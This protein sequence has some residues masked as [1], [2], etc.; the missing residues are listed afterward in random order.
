MQLNKKNRLFENNR[1]IYIAVDN[2]KPNPAQPRK[3]FDQE[4][5]RE[6]SESIMKFGV[7]QPLSVRKKSD[8][9]ELIA[10][11]RRLRAAKLAGLGE[12]PCILLGVDREQSS[13]LAL[14]ENLQRQDLDF[15]EEAE[16][17]A[18]LILSFGLSQEEAA[19][20]IGKSQSAVANKLRILKHPQ[21]VLDKLRQYNL[22]ERHARAL[23]RLENTQDRLDAIEE[24]AKNS[25]NVAQTEELVEKILNSPGSKAAR[26]VHRSFTY[27]IKD[28]RIFENTI[29]HAVSIM[30]DSG[31]KADYGKEEDE[32]SI[33]LTIKIP[34]RAS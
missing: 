13:V 20:K 15:I 21:E 2:I 23:L 14:I 31:V 34:K 3:L 11:E 29:K 1:I 19:R 27:I 7:L 25:L 17:I 10:G 22:T 28:F 6:L 24:I 12:V 33:T 18:R 8:H 26:K 5:L 32:N 9:Y 16:G 30:R 4:G